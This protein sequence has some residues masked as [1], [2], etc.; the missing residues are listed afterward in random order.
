MLSFSIYPTTFFMVRFRWG[1]DPTLQL[2][3]DAFTELPTKS[4]F[5]ISKAPFLPTGRKFYITPLLA[6]FGGK[7]LRKRQI[8]VARIHTMLTEIIMKNDMLSLIF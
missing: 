4:E 6:L 5:D 3:D 2:Y 8:I 1:R 7:S